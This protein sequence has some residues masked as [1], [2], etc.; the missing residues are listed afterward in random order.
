MIL[1]SFSKRVT[2]YYAQ[3]IIKIILNNLERYSLDEVLP[4]NSVMRNL[5][6]V[7]SV[8]S[9]LPTD[10]LWIQ[11]S[12]PHPY[13]HTLHRYPW[14]CSLRTKGKPVDHLCAV[15]L[16]SIPPKPTVVIGSSHC[17]YVCKHSFNKQVEVCC[18]SEGNINCS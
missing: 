7:S 11:G 12:Q 14:V 3:I 2:E 15:N 17:T 9:R 5:A 16:L 18:C 8:E 6:N 4:K 1:N 13:R 10:I